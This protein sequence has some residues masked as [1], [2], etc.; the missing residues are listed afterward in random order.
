MWKLGTDPA[1]RPT[2]SSYASVEWGVRERRR[3]SVVNGDALG[4]MAAAL[5]ARRSARSFACLPESLLSSLLWHSARTQECGQLGSGFD[6]EHRPAPS[7]GAIHPIH[8][9]IQLPEEDGWARYNPLEHSL[10]VLAKAGS[11][12]RPLVEF[13][14]EVVS[15]QDGRLMLFVAEPGMTSAK[16]K[17]SES[18]VWRDA[19]VLQG[20]ISLVAAALD[21]NFCLLGVTGNP[22]VAQLSSEC[23]LQGVGIATLGARP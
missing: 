13:S 20:I 7:A 23:K 3:L 16:Y 11:V 12:L 1:P 18:L 22:W 15:K 21:L 17:R 4:S 9:L 8:L 19:G 14:E 6:V 5:D 10:D 2:P